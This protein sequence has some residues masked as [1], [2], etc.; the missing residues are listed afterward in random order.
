MN[1]YMGTDEKQNR[2]ES[3]TDEELVV[4]AQSGDEQASEQILERYKSLVKARVRA[5][6]LIGAD[7]EDLIQE[8]M[9]GLFK[10]IRD[11]SADKQVNF[12]SFA[13]LCATRQI[14]TAIKTATRQKHM[15]LNNYISLNKPAYTDE[16]ERTLMDS[17]SYRDVS[18]P[19]QIVINEED[20]N[21]TTKMIL[22]SLS[23]FER[24]VLESYLQGRSYSEIAQLQ[25]RSSK[26]ID[27]A[28]QRIKKKIEASLKEEK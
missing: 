3:M 11:F 28:L 22:G 17:V 25:G 2:F 4:L 6:F 5:Y 16:S 21:N 12:A 10:A 20:Y 23:K 24:D 27:N 9:I 14:V 7:K 15:P 19:E 18:D 8:G 26:S 1:G 13:D